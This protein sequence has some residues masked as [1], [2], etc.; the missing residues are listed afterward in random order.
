[1]SR[2]P[3]FERLVAIMARLRGEGGCPWDR[4]QDHS[5]LR[6]Y[7][8]EEAYEVLEAIDHVEREGG[9][10]ALCE[11]LG[12]LLLQVVFHAQ[13]ESE[14]GAFAID[15]VARSISDK[16]ERRHPHVFGGETLTSSAEVSDRWAEHKKKEG[17]RTLSGVP[18]ALPALLRAYRVT[19]KAASVGFDWQRPEDVLD[20]IEEEIGELREALATGRRDEVKHELGDLLFAMTNLGR[21]L[22]IDPDE[23]LGATI[24]R[25]TERF[26]YVEDALAARKLTPG[27][28]SLEELDRL[29]EEA[30]ALERRGG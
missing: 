28:V 22:R 3:E 8:V 26:E 19:E 23:A 27:V 14:R 25:F 6:T 9:P 7:L 12:D 11:E 4:E 30:K 13:I 20:K 29:W 18:R 24:D 2:V 10:A 17:R 16:M 15:D 21:H 5:S 1:V